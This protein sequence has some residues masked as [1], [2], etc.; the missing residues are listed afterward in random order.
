MRVRDG[1]I[2]VRVKGLGLGSRD[3]LMA[4]LGLGRVRVLGVG[5][6]DRLKAGLG[7]VRVS[8]FGFGV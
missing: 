8:G 3:R 2:R 5:F 4:R 7:R 1:V 6:R